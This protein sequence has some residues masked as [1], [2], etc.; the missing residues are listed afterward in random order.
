MNMFQLE[1]TR[2]F[3]LKQFRDYVKYMYEIAAF[4]GKDKLKSVFTFADNDVV[5]ESFLEDIQNMLN[6]GVVPNL[7]GNEEL[8]KIRDECRKPFKRA[9][10]GAVESPDAIQEFFFD[11]IKNNLHLS[12]CMSP[13]GRAFRDYT[14]MFPALIN[15]T[16]LDWFM[17][18]PDDAL[19]EV[20][21]KFISAMELGEEVEIGLA[22]LCAVAH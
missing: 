7:Y 12:V 10:P 13:I 3:G 11:N 16:T 2:G 17:K 20:A 19:T 8:A 6:A 4:R 14:R 1:I 21:V 9:N 18:W 5:H 22:K 15:N